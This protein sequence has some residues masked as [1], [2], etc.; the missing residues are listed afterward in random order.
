MPSHI[1]LIEKPNDWRPDFPRIQILT[2]GEYLARPDLFKPRGTHLINFCRSYRYLS[3]GY[4]CSLLAGARHH[5]ILPSVHTL[6]ALSRKTLYSLDLENLDRTLQKIH[7]QG[8]PS[9]GESLELNIYFG[10][11]EEVRMQGLARQIFELLPCPILKVSLHHERRWGIAS[12]QPVHLHQLSNL[13]HESFTHAL[14]S[15]LSKPWRLPKSRR[16]ARFDLAILHE[17]GE[18]KP[19]SNAGALRKFVQAGKKLGVAVEL[20]QKKDFNRVTEFDA[21]FLRTT[22]A[23]DHYTYRFARKAHFEGMAVIDD[24]DSI[25][26]CT[27]KVYLAELLAGQQISHPRTVILQKRDRKKLPQPLGFPIVLKIPDGSFSKGVLK[28]NDENEF[29]QVCAQ[30]FKASDLI[31][32]QEFIYTPFDWRIGI[33]NHEPLYACRYFMSRR[34]WQIVKYQRSGRIEEGGFETLAIEQAPKTVVDTAV[35]AA[36]HIGDGLYGVDLKQTERGVFVIEINDNPN[37]DSG[38]EDKVLGESLYR[39]IMADFIRRIDNRR[40]GDAYFTSP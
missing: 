35:L 32:A 39:Q 5:K 1:V 15:Y 22:T 6:T 18:K 17:P 20:I 2:A 19:P 29:T 23:I 7:A 24:P 26:R 9:D 8:Q 31:L 3:S 28:A 11:A 10:Q 34:H 12:I 16:A 37:I 30:L 40:E 14:E 36:Q 21:L 13:Q 33:L 25:I 4:Y 27:N 38:I